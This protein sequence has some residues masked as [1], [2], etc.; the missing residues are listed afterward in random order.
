MSD[1]N[2]NVVPW[3]GVTKLDLD[4]TKVCQAAAD[5]GLQGVVICGYDADG[6]EYFASSYADGG[7]VLWHLQR[8]SLKIL[9]YGDADDDHGG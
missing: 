2:D 4:P 5:A 7:D 8:A 6:N 1:E 9:R 3:G